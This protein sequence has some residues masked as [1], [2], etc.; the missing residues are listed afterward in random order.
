MIGFLLAC[1]KCGR[2]LEPNKVAVTAEAVRAGCWR[3][4]P[5]YQGE[6]AAEGRCTRCGRP[7]RAGKRT[8]CLQ[9]LGFSAA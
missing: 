1:A 2:G 5:N 8:L 3:T 9:C 6:L 7:L 4:C